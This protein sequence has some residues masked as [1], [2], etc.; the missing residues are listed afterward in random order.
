[1][2]SI[3]KA[4]ARPDDVLIAWQ[5]D[6]LSD[7]SVGF[8]LEP[9]RYHPTGDRLG[10]PDPT[11]ALWG[12]DASH[13]HLVNPIRDPPLS[14]GYGSQVRTSLFPIAVDIGHRCAPVRT[15]AGG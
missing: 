4:Y 1:M 6:T 14:F 15:S 3:I 11:E 12:T 2:S 5:P 10:Q 13:R 7:D 8:Q 9:Q